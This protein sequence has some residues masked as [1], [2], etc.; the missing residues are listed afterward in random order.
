MTEILKDSDWVSQ[1][2]DLASDD[3]LS[4]EVLKPAITVALER[5]ER[6]GLP[7]AE[8]AGSPAEFLN[9]CHEE[10]L[11]LNP[12]QRRWWQWA[13]L[14]TGIGLAFNTLLAL[15]E[16][17]GTLP[18]DY[19]QLAYN[20]GIALVV[21]FWAWGWWRLQHGLRLPALLSLAGITTVFV[22]VTKVNNSQKSG[23]LTDTALLTAPWYYWAIA[24][25]LTLAAARVCRLKWPAPPVV[26][27][28]NAAWLRALRVILFFRFLRRP[29]EIRKSVAD[30]FSDQQ[31]LQNGASLQETYGNVA[32]Y[33]AKLV[34]T[35][36]RTFNRKLK[37][38][39]LASPL[40]L[41]MAISSL[42]RRI[43]T[44]ESIS[45]NVIAVGVLS[46]GTILVWRRLFTKKQLAKTQA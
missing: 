3:G 37:R 12:T 7:V 4:T 40:L 22:V 16:F 15:R 31:Q 27:R 33:A 42:V 45:F 25:A 39:A 19:F 13:L 14:G 20:I 35:S 28:D 1:V 26:I 36:P 43:D 6:H 30:V 9:S 44:G 46:I 23:A 32:A 24:G 8:V 2:K 29:S 41:A 11:F 38:A 21:G 18:V 17:N 10:G 34:A 5:A